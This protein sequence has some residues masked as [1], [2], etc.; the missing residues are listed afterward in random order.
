[1]LRLSGVD[2]LHPD[3]LLTLILPAVDEYIKTATGHDYGADTTIDAS[4]KMAASMLVV[5]WYENPAMIGQVDTMQYGITNL[6]EQL[7]AKQLPAE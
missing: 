3:P 6:L 7:R 2:A 1:M 4:A 5:Q